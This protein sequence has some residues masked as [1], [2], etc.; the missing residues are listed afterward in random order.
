MIWWGGTRPDLEQMTGLGTNAM[1][2]F[3]LPFGSQ[4][5]RNPEALPLDPLGR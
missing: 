5:R 4:L 1:P 3:Q 2:L